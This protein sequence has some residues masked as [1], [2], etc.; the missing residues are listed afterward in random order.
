MSMNQRPR[1]REASQRA[2]AVRTARQEA[3]RKR[4]WRRRLYVPASVLAVVFVVAAAFLLLRDTGPGLG[5]TVPE[6]PA[7][8][9]AP[10]FYNT[11][12]IIDGVPAEIPPT[13]GS[14][15]PT[16]SPY[17]FLGGPVLAEAVVHNMEHGSVVIWYQPGDPNLAGSINRLVRELGDRCIVAGSYANMSFEVAVTVWG[18]VLPQTEFDAEELLEFVR[19]YRGVLGPEAGICGQAT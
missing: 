7:R 2:Q 10:Y 16:S 9:G 13:S 5:F 17:G 12:L 19:A 11:S 1:R 15:E 18:R 6:L 8:H 4:E 3:R 14:M